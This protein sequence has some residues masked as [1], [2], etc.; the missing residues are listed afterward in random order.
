[1]TQDEFRA[2]T[3]VLTMCDPWGAFQY[4]YVLDAVKRQSPSISPSDAQ[5]AAVTY[6]DNVTTIPELGKC[7]I[8]L[9]MGTSTAGRH[10]RRSRTPRWSS[11]RCPEKP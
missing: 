5:N 4:Y 9:G 3:N 10:V 1:M 2:L 7:G 8:N 11:R 6:F